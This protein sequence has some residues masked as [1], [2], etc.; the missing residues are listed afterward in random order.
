MMDEP[1]TIAED[2]GVQLQARRASE[3]PIDTIQCV[4]SK[5][6]TRLSRKS[7]R[8]RN[9]SIDSVMEEIPKM[10][11]QEFDERRLSRVLTRIATQV[12]QVTGFEEL[13]E[14]PPEEVQQ[15]LETA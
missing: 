7:T 15:W 10:I 12:T 5:V 1:D 8:L 11:D 14:F 2:L 13:G 6:S 9:K 3:P 4:L